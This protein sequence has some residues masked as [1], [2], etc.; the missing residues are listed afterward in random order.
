[1]IILN[2]LYAIDTRK[3]NSLN[4]EDTMN[5]FEKMLFLKATSLFS[6]INEDALLNVAHIMEEEEVA[7]GKTIIHLGEISDWMYVIVKGQVKVHNKESIFK[8]MGAKDVFGELSAFLLDKRIASVTALEDCLLLKINQPK[9]FQLI[10]ALPD[11]SLGIIQFL[12]SRIRDIA[13][14]QRQIS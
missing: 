12:C 13:I 7:A 14:N 8:I 6:S 5:T 3:I 2:S 11:F 9:I 1:M 4:L 10:E